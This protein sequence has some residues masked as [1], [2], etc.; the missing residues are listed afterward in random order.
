MAKI[1]VIALRYHTHEGTDYQAG[2]R[3]EVDADHV[4][5]LEANRMVERVD[6]VPP[7]PDTPPEAT[8][9]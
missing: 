5:F 8:G 2:D 4:S 3:Y 9:P 6:P 7:P 1:P